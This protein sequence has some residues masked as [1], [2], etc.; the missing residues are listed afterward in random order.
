MDEIGRGDGRWCVALALALLATP[1]L[2]DP[3]GSDSLKS[4]PYVG[5]RATSAGTP[6]AVAAG[7]EALLGAVLLEVTPGAPAARAGLRRGD[8]IVEYGGVEIQYA[9]DLESAVR[10]S[11]I[12]GRQR[13]V[14]VRGT[15]RFRTDLTIGSQPV[16]YSHLRYTHA[17]GGYRFQVLPGWKELPQD[18][19]DR[20]IERQ[21]DIVESS[22]GHYRLLCFKGSFP[23]ADPKAALQAFASDRLKEIPDAQSSR[24]QLAGA[25]AACVAHRLESDGRILWRISF[26]SHGRRYVINANGPPYVELSKPARAVTDVLNTLELLPV[27][28]AAGPPLAQN[29]AVQTKPAA[30]A[31]EVEPPPGWTAQRA[32]GLQLYL[33]PQWQASQF[34]SADEGRWL[35]GEPLAPEAS[36]AVVRDRELDELTRGMKVLEKTEAKLA[37]QQALR[38]LVEIEE[39]HRTTRGMLVAMNEPD[40]QGSMVVFTCYCAAEAWKHYGPLFDKILGTARWPSSP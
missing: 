5:L 6:A 11:P 22:D 24:F 14:F 13:V 1:V 25:P 34:A 36:V 30:S 21:F 15:Q 39:T 33:P 32:G 29:A 17:G 18:Q 35:F 8:L 28:E 26:V 37:K 38:V 23:A 27:G 9:E 16:N 7:V 20:P 3:P 2:G 12:G 4:K 40:P 10:H 19:P 31:E